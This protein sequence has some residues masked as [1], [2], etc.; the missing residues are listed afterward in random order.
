MWTSG[1]LPDGGIAEQERKK[2]NVPNV[3]TLNGRRMM[4]NSSEPFPQALFRISPFVNP[5][6]GRRALWL[7]DAHFF[8][9][10]GLSAGNGRL[11]MRQ[12]CYP[13]P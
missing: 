11:P 6:R 7:Q 4:L 12:P 5:L 2:A 8:D 3:T 9:T 13:V 10:E 1:A